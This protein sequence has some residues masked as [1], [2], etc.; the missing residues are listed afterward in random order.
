MYVD[1]DDRMTRII[2]IIQESE[3]GIHDISYME[4]DGKSNLARFNMP[5]EL[6]IDYAHKKFVS[7][8]KKLLIMEKVPYL[9]KKALSDLSGNDIVAHNNEPVEVVKSIRNFFVGTYELNNVQHQTA[10][11]IEYETE[12]EFWL[13]EKLASLGYPE[14]KYYSMDITI[15][16]YIRFVKDFF[17]VYNDKLVKTD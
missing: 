14:E 15:I 1:N 10:I 11:L 7:D 8:N 12:F 2:K 3:I 6:G 13:K 4:F 16:E 9:S 5:F 17:I